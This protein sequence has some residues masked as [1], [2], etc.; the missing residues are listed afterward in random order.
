MAQVA[1]TLKTACQ[2]VDM[3]VF[4]HEKT[5]LLDAALEKCADGWTKDHFHQ[6]TQQVLSNDELFDEVCDEYARCMQNPTGNVCYFRIHCRKFCVRDRRSCFQYVLRFFLLSVMKEFTRASLSCLP[7][8]VAL[9]EIYARLDV[10]SKRAWRIAEPRIYRATKLPAHSFPWRVDKFKDDPF[11]PHVCQL[12]FDGEMKRFVKW[13][14]QG[15][16]L[17]S[18]CDAAY[19]QAAA[20]GGSVNIH[21]FLTTRLRE[22][23]IQTELM[24]RVAYACAAARGH[25]DFLGIVNPAYLGT[26][27]AVM[28]WLCILPD[29]RKMS[30]WMQDHPVVYWVRDRRDTWVDE[31]F[32][33]Y[34]PHWSRD[35][36]KEIIFECARRGYLEPIKRY[37][38]YFNRR[39]VEDL[40]AF[41][42]STVVLRFLWVHRPDLFERRDYVI[43]AALR[44]GV[45]EIIAW[46]FEVECL[47]WKRDAARIYSTA[48][49]NGH[50]NLLDWMHANEAVQ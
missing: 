49:L 32:E 47:Q 14:E 33:T 43:A 4:A 30:H 38:R 8:E 28:Q 16:R 24:E 40:L 50:E 3:Q 6:C 46:L 34:P 29:P 27:K 21:Q 26:R 18:V 17:H 23:G 41:A 37:Y 11:F 25:L 44:Y 39:R 35:Y 15:T 22:A 31:F 10:M 5:A 36:Q 1:I 13:R 9:E 20:M 12:A 48:R 42:S 7:L 2:P 45:P 19:L